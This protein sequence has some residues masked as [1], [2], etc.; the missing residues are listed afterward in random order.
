MAP[1]HLVL[2]RE[3]SSQPSLS[4][5]SSC[6]GS[7]SSS[8]YLSSS[9]SLS[10]PPPPTSPPPPPAAIL[11]LW[12]PR[13]RVDPGARRRSK[14][15]SS[16]PF[17]HSSSLPKFKTPPHAAKS[18]VKPYSSFYLVCFFFGIIEYTMTNEFHFQRLRNPV[19]AHCDPY[20]RSHIFPC[21]QQV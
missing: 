8:S 14:P 1:S 4:S 21:I 9:S 10:A 18:P 20:F 13:Q 15:G 17:H 19:N 5:P 2:V 16:P 11:N 3:V 7:S 6:L 12:F